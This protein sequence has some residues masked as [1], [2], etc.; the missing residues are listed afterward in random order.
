MANGTTTVIQKDPLK[1]T[2]TNNYRLI[3]CLRMMWKILTAQIRKK[4]YYSL[5]S[6][7]IF[8]NEQK[9]CRKITRGTGELVSIAQH[10]LKEGKTRQKKSSYGLD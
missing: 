10:I 4:I 2:T 1:E 3:T 9:R 5:I 6:H 7:R 8:P